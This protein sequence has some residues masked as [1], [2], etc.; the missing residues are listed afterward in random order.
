MDPGRRLG[1]ARANGVWRSRRSQLYARAHAP[2]SSIGER[3]PFRSGFRW[4]VAPAKGYNLGEA[5]EITIDVPGPLSGQSAE[6][7]VD[8]AR[9]LL[10]IDEVRGERL[11]RVAAARALRMTLDEFLTEA[12]RHGLYAIDYDV[13]DFRRELAVVDSSRT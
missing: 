13:E 11:T 6:A 7:L 8:R 5:M 3:T 1:Y 2:T 4:P 12:G 10:V 9:L